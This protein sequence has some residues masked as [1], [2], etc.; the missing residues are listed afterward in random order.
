[1][2]MCYV[3]AKSALELVQA[4]HGKYEQTSYNLVGGNVCLY[5]RSK[6][7]YILWVCFSL[8]QHDI[9]YHLVIHVRRNI[10]H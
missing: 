10:D 4:F 1:M 6:A 7:R 9:F 2:A 3:S 5:V 8:R